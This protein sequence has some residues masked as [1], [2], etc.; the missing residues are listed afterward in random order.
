MQIDP[1]LFYQ[2]IQEYVDWNLENLYKSK[3]DE[4][5][6]RFIKTILG[7]SIP[8]NKVCEHH[9]APMDFIADSFFDR[10][11]KLLVV[12][13]RNGG[14]TQNFGILN[15]LDG[16]CKKGCEIAS[17]GAI[18]DQAKKC[19]KYTVDI[20]R[21]PY[22]AKLLSKEPMISLT[23]LDNGSEISILPGTMS[24]LMDLIHKELTLTKWNLHN[25]KS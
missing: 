8:R 6:Y 22:F 4:L 16:I 12:A 13:N 20:I 7:F 2:K 17:V 3:D 10:V 11:S 25:G 23:K 24:E 5:L 15:A 9:C 1:M 21:K 14:K 18:E 19:Y